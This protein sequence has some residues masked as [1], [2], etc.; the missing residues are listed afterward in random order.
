MKTAFLNRIRS[1]VGTFAGQRS[2]RRSK[3]RSTS[4]MCH[5]IEAVERRL[6]PAT[7][8]VNLAATSISEGDGAQ[9]TTATI[10]RDTA[11][12]TPLIVRL[13]SSDPSEAT[14]PTTIT[15][16]AGRLASASFHIAAVD[17]TRV[18][19]RQSVTIS[20]LAAGHTSGQAILAVVDNDATNINA[21]VLNAISN[22]QQRPTI[23]WNQV[24]NAAEYEVW[25]AHSSAGQTALINQKVTTA[26]FTPNADM[27]LGTFAVWVR[28]ING[29]QQSGWST[30]QKFS[31]NE[32][33]SSVTADRNATTGQIT[34]QWE[35][36][37]GA[38]TYELWVNNITT[39]KARAVH[40]AALTSTSFTLPGTAGIDVMRVWVRAKNPEGF[41]SQWS[42]AATSP[43]P[44]PV[45]NSSVGT[46]LNLR[47]QF[48]W[49]ALPG[50]AQYEIFISNSG[51]PV[52][53]TTGGTSFTPAVDLSFGT[54]R[55]WVRG[56]TSDGQ[57]GSWSER[58]GDVIVGGAPA[59]PAPSVI[60]GSLTFS[61]SA[62]DSASSYII[63][64]SRANDDSSTK[65]V[66]EPVTGTTFRPTKSLTSGKYR[67]WV[68]AISSSGLRSRWNSGTD[69]TIS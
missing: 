6:L 15:I 9:A 51:G 42:A 7:L 45:L 14:V 27:G 18:D 62:V 28:S 4:A 37:T 48:A 69:F 8:S 29:Q 13:S 19:G 40:E 17:D 23:T 32:F 58:G 11:G 10:S 1:V 16:P 50:A 52:V 53:A 65:V 2:H 30:G 59:V 12:T 67:V 57:K 31:N 47:P 41:G 24:S 63:E 21:P 60:S 64:V 49:Q 26:S 61:W 5:N 44:R 25:I 55:W 22:N 43:V 3:N 34:V 54:H 56:V 66:R 35:A 39:G 20:A 38:S 46:T 36:V 68:Q 33:K